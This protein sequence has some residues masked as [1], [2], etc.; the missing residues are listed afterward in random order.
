MSEEKSE[1]I[2]KKEKMSLAARLVHWLV[3]LTFVTPIVYAKI[4]VSETVTLLAMAMY[5]ALGVAFDI[6]NFK[7]RV[8]DEKPPQ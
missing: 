8:Q 4:G 3:I 2:K 1:P 6:M 5:G 7:H